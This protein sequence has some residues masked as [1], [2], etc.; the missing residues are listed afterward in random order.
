MFL[1]GIEPGTLRITKFQVPRFPPLSY[2]DGRITDN[3]LGPS[4]T[5][6]VRDRDCENLD[7]HVT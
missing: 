5:S 6:A 4:Y 2:G 1:A 3:P 7:L